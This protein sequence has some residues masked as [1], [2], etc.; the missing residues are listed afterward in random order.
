[1]VSILKPKR[2]FAIYFNQYS[3]PLRLQIL[4][5]FTASNAGVDIESL[6]RAIKLFQYRFGLE[7]NGELDGATLSLMSQPRCGD[8]GKIIIRDKN[9]GRFS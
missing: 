8:K 4:N 2:L 5:S 1:M 9:E 3:I 7:V 6:K